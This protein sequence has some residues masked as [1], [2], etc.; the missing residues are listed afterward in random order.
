MVIDGTLRLVIDSERCK[1]D[2]A[3]VSMYHHLPD[4]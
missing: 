3:H 2:V 4:S 1:F